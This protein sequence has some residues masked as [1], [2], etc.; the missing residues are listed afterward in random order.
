MKIIM[1]AIALAIAAPAMAQAG[2]QPSHAQHQGNAQ[3]QGHDQAQH[4]QHQGHGQ[5]QQGHAGCCAD[6]NGD[7]RMDCCERMAEAG[8]RRGCCP[9]PA[10]QPGSQPQG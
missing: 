3:H 5:H 7:G 6:R 4:G 1:T 10:A 2:A 9:A 8:D